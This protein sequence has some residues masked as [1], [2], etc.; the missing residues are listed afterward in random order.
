[1]CNQTPPT[2]ACSIS[3]DRDLIPSPLSSLSSNSRAVYYGDVAAMYGQVQRHVARQEKEE[4]TPEVSASTRVFPMHGIT[5]SL[6]V[7]ALV[8][9]ETL[10][11]EDVVM[12]HNEPQG[13]EEALQSFQAVQAELDNV[14]ADES[15]G[16]L[17]M[18]RQLRQRMA[19]PPKT[20]VEVALEEVFMEQEVTGPSTT[21]EYEAGFGL[22]PLEDAESANMS[23]LDS[24]LS[25]VAAHLGY[26]FWRYKRILHGAPIMLPDLIP[27]RGIPQRADYMAFNIKKHDGEPTI[28]STMGGNNPIFCNVLHA[29]PQLDIATGTKGDNV[30]LLGECFQMDS[31]ITR[32]I[33]AIGDAGVTADIIRLRKFS[34]RKCKTQREHQRLGHLADFLTAEWCRHY[35]EE[36]QMRDQEKATIERLVAARTMERME[37]YLHYHDDHAY[38]THSHMHND[39]LWGSW[40]EIE[41]SS[42]QET[43]KSLPDMYGSWEAPCRQ[44]GPPTEVNTPPTA[45]SLLS[46]ASQPLTAEQRS[47]ITWKCYS[48]CKYCTITGHF[49]KDCTVPHCLCYQI[50]RDKCS[51]PKA[52]HHYLPLTKPTCLYVGLP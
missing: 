27:A 21:T 31:A 33:E 12:D 36:R 24:Q 10:T 42:G 19:G 44:V 25:N 40:N 7:L 9:N 2:P 23:S 16:E 45:S 3:P 22:L 52:H 41:Q 49:A 8:C 37:P 11:K 5:N 32:A 47:K 26:P 46:S 39:I 35:A 20:L 29:D 43:C 14:L 13:F 17:D 34:E 1:M 48:R 51:V 6:E 4:I 28:Y 30:Y 38:L 15:D 18:S 50:G